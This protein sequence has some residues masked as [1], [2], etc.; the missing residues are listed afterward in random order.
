MTP[1]DLGAVGSPVDVATFVMVVVAWL[2]Q[3]SSIELL[4]AGQVALAEGRRDVDH[5]RIRS[6]HD[7]DE[8]D[9]DSLRPTVVTD[10]GPNDA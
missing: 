9:V 1:V 7:V 5:E 10:G 3:R 4:A 8:R 6:E 2:E